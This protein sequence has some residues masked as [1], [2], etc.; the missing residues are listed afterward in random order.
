MGGD[1]VGIWS[2]LPRAVRVSVVA[3]LQFRLL[4][5]G[6]ALVFAFG[7]GFGFAFGSG[8]WLRLRLWRPMFEP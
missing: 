1:A 2:A 3:V 8:F 6:F 7:F 4:E 5:L